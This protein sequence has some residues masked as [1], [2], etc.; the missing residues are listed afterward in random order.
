MT[1]EKLLK[2]LLM[3]QDLLHRSARLP[4]PCASWSPFWWHREE[5]SPG[6]PAGGEWGLV[7]CGPPGLP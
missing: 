2:V 3:R 6:S 4:P 5:W 1:T 7:L